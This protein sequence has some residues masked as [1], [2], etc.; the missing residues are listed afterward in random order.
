[1]RYFL[2]LG[3]NIG[4]PRRNLDKA[5]RLLRI[6]GAEIVRASSLYRTEPVDFADQPW[7]I[8]QVIEV[9]TGYDP[10]AFLRMTKAIEAQ[11]KRHPSVPK[12]P[13]TIDIDIL[14]AG[15]FVIAMPELTIPHPRLALR[16]FVLI[17]LKE[18]AP[19]LV[20]PTCHKTI[21]ELA[22]QSPDKALVRK[23]GEHFQSG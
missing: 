7:F 17:P 3:S 21:E 19:D 15:S 5:T 1:M 13:R 22:Y 2:S 8:N 10:Q 11:M 12:G 23:I 6:H 4:N 14:L 18:I 9:E 16:N 20:H